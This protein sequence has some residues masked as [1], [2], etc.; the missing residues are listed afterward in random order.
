MLRVS[1]D[2]RHGEPVTIDFLPDAAP[3]WRLEAK[4]ARPRATLGSA[5]ALPDRLAQTLAERLALAGELGA[6]TDRKLAEADAQLKR[7]PFHPNCTEDFAKAELHVGG[8][9][10][11]NLSSQ[12]MMAQRVP[13]PAQVNTE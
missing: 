5:L 10:T 13:T 1:S 9:S 8:I 11:A 2:W 12:K 6:L 7:W 4:R 3:G